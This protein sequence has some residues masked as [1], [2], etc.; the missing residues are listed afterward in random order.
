MRCL[1]AWL[2]PGQLKEQE[3]VLLAV[4]NNADVT[5]ACGGSH[6]CAR[7]KLTPA[8]CLGRQHLVAKPVTRTSLHW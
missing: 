4:N 3:L 6:W 8:L 1:K 5:T 2:H 7:S